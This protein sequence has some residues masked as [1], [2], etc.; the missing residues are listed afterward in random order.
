MPLFWLDPSLRIRT[1][2][3]DEVIAEYAVEDIMSLVGIQPNGVYEDY[4]DEQA[5]GREA[6]LGARV[7]D[8]F[9]KHD[10][11]ESTIYG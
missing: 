4:A 11:S 10:R 7:A 8:D 9:G 3:P 6:R 1:G 2:C 5:L